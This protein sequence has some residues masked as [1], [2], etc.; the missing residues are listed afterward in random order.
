MP[1]SPPVTLHLV[2]VVKM[3]VFPDSKIQLGP[4]IDFNSEE[5][6][7]ANADTQRMSTPK[8]KNE[9]REPSNKD[10]DAIDPTVVLSAVHELLERLHQKSGRMEERFKSLSDH[11]ECMNMR[12]HSLERENRQNVYYHPTTC[13][14][15]ELGTSPHG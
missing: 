3:D 13:H 8:E 14:E 12:V 4:S 11:V 6:E 2:A 7:R 15:G 9:V 5:L 1:E 10:D